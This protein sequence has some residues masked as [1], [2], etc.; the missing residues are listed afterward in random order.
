MAWPGHGA[1]KLILSQINLSA[2]PP[3]RIPPCQ[4]LSVFCTYRVPRQNSGRAGSHQGG[5]G[6]SSAGM[7]RQWPQPAA[8]PVGWLCTR[9]AHRAL[10]PSHSRGDRGFAW[11]LPP[12]LCVS[13][14]SVCF[15][16]PWPFRQPKLQVLSGSF[17]LISAL[18]WSPQLAVNT[19]QTQKDRTFHVVNW[20]VNKKRGCFY[21]FIFLKR[22]TCLTCIGQPFDLID[23]LVPTVKLI[24]WVNKW[25]RAKG[26][27]ASVLPS[28]SESEK[29]CYQRNG[30]SKLVLSTGRF[31]FVN[32][33]Q[34]HLLWGFKNTL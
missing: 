15:C 11:A 6:Q 23:S 26:F 34:L 7:G 9:P 29:N 32:K 4:L 27:K 1:A 16:G 8:F 3:P 10:Q 2:L 28:W 17:V 5:G 30:V 22:V 12:A 21:F 18:S 33:T 24:D 13:L 20:V 31:Y 19:T 25:E 14:I